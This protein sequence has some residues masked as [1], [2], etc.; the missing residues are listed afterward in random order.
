MRPTS[1]LTALLTLVVLGLP[2]WAKDDGRYDVVV[3]GTKRGKIFGSDGGVSFYCSENRLDMHS[4]PSPP[5]YSKV[6]I[7]RPRGDM[8]KF[9]AAFG[10][11]CEL[12]RNPAGVIT[13]LCPDGRATPIGKVTYTGT[14]VTGLRANAFDASGKALGYV[15]W[16]AL[17]SGIYTP[18][19]KKI[20]TVG[21]SADQDM[22]ASAIAAFF[23]P[24]Q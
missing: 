14:T 9:V 24:C 5:D 7:F 18:A 15:Y 6:V 10:G 20:G 16:S 1:R 23:S 12:A 4:V 8:A 17:S 2:A 19:D 11:L 13:K 3:N 22:I 21:S